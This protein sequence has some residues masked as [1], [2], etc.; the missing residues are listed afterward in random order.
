MLRG[1]LSEVGDGLALLLL[2]VGAKVC[3]RAVAMARRSDLVVES[4]C[5]AN[6][7]MLAARHDQRHRNGRQSTG[8]PNGFIPFSRTVFGNL[9]VPQ[10]MKEPK[11][12]YQS[13]SGATGPV[14]TQDWSRWRSPIEM[15]RSSTRCRM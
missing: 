11:S 6:P 8:S 7:K 4:T 15:R 2:Q 14:R 3:K 5:W 1:S 12:L 13:P 10:R 9:P